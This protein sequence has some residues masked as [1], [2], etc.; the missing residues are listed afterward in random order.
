M[1]FLCNFTSLKL[2]NKKYLKMKKLL[3]IVAALAVFGG[4]MLANPVDVNT[5]KD[6]GVKYLKNNVVSAKNV[7][8]AQHVYTLSSENG[9]PYPKTAI[10]VFCMMY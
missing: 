3:V 10:L 7:T 1:K 8:D 6:L 2:E 4:Q 9:T 5:A